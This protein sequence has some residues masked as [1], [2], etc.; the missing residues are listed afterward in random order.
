M[1][2]SSVTRITL[3]THTHT[4]TFNLIKII[5]GLNT[6]ICDMLKRQTAIQ[7]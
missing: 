2:K 7:F 6:F 5:R 4:H 3:H 1:V